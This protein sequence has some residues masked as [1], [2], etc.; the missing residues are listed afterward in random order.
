[1]SVEVTVTVSPKSAIPPTALR[2]DLLRN[3][4]QLSS[5][6][7]LDITW[8]KPLASSSRASGMFLLSS[9]ICPVSASNSSPLFPAMVLALRMAVSK[10][11]KGSASPP[12]MSL[13]S[14]IER[15]AVSNTRLLSAISRSLLPVATA[16]FP[17]SESMS[18][19]PSASTVRRFRT[20]PSSLLMFILNSTAFAIV[21]SYFSP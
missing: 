11:S 8:Y 3:S 19:R 18:S 4:I 5:G 13:R 7:P 2:L 9:V 15:T 14:R 16:V 6:T 1:M 12:T 17:T 20:P 21:F 10:L